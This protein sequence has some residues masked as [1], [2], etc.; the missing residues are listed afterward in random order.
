VAA[1]EAQTRGW[2]S[3]GFVATLCV[4]A[5]AAGLG[6]TPA[7]AIVVKI[8][9]HAYGI[10]P[11]K[12]VGLEKIPASHRTA[13]PLATQPSGPHNFD[14]LPQGG[15][16]LLYNG[17][18]VMHSVTTH[19]VYW[20]PE[21]EFTPTTKGVVG[22]FFGDVAH[23]SGQASNVFPVAGQ[24]TDGTGH[25]A[26][27]STFGGALPDKAFYP[28]TGNCT[29]PGG[30]GVDPGPPYTT[31]LF[32]SQ[33]KEGLS[34]FI[35]AEKL[36]TGSAQQYFVLFPHKVV[37][38]FNETV[39]EEE[40]F[41]QICSNNF[42]CAYHGAINGGKPSEIIYSDIPFSL[43]D[44]G[45]AKGCQDDGNGAIQLPNGDVG[46][47]DTE[48]RFADVALK[49]TSHEYIEAS[50]D[51]LGTGYFD[52]NGNE[53]GDKCNGVSP[54]E[55]EDGIGYDANSFLPTLGGSAG[56]GTLFDQSI[57]ADSYYLQSEWDNAAKACKMNPVPISGA[58]FKPEPSSGGV[59]APISFKGVATDIYAGLS[60]VWKWGD[61]T[62]SAGASP[63]HAYGAVGSYEVTMTPKDELTSAT[64]APVVHT[65]VVGKGS[66]AIAFTSSPPS[67]ANVGAS[68][69]VTAEASPSKLPAVLTI[70]P[71]SASVCSIVGAKVE[72][73]AVGSCTID[74]NQAGNANYNA[75][76]QVQQV[77]PVKKG[78]TI[79]FISTA[80]GSAIV[81]GPTYEASAEAKPSGLPVVL[82]IDASSSAV[83]T[84][85]G[86]K[87]SFIGAGMCT[88]D[89]NQGGDSN[90]NPAPQVQQSVAVTVRVILGS[91]LPGGVG[92]APR[93]PNSLFTTG[94]TS[95]N[96]TTG[97]LTFTATVGD[98]GTFRWLVT[99][100]NGKFGVFVA[101]SHKCKAGFLRLG[102][103]CW[104]SKIVFAKGSQVVAAPGTVTFKIKPSA[105]AL[106]ALKNA[107]KHKKGLPVT[108]TFTFQ[109]ARGGSAVSHTQSLTVKLK[110]K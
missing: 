69:E 66:Q 83:C 73:K 53:I 20:D 102:G 76:P 40:E 3:A 9:G 98:P 43:L 7:G 8:G 30:F 18:P 56:A 31:C 84:I 71:S 29:V 34:A 13:R 27:S 2:R 80:P 100:Q 17:G 54:D 52:A 105:S 81:G 67:P 59:G 91:G 58:G 77:I 93:Q 25:A 72:F 92:P 50:T 24:Y 85:S 89:A 64:A 95:F 75:A 10:T 79:L 74:A 32:D 15:G 99:F 44:N 57:N 110:M 12:G 16:P 96:Q 28:S 108:A 21:N 4:L 45:N 86:S 51:P 87:V 14:G 103:K 33:V 109:S 5:F 70:N 106:K 60:F 22:K 49:Y 42:F 88:I 97:L 39:K 11:I 1:R 90:Y 37:T 61:G 62:E 68:Y 23:D 63:T 41:G 19:V 78:Q 104:P 26:Y 38:C 36:P 35:S 94:A 65:I 47:S 107:V 6:A 82:T 46:T 48:T 55:K 101:S